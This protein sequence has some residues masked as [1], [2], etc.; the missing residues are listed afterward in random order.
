MRW[1][2]NLHV[3]LIPDFFG[4]KY[5]KQL[6]IANQ[7]FEIL[8]SVKTALRMTIVCILFLGCE[9]TDGVFENP[10]DREVASENGITPPAL[11]FYPDVVTTTAG[12][13]AATSVYALDISGVGM[14]EI[15]INYNQNKVSVGSVAK[16]ELF[17]GGNQ[18]FFHYEDDGSGVLT[19]YIG[20]LG[21]DGNSVSG[22]GNIANI[23]F[24]TLSAGQSE[25]SISTASRILDPDAKAITLN[26]YGKGTIDAQ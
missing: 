15:V 22:T 14:A 17:Q 8:R 6:W 13:S 4:K 19:V 16:G 9:L 25:V 20:Y 21:P 2:N 18:P 23:V 11:V 10:L 26:G 12:G 3:I 1:T 24:S 7:K 5:L